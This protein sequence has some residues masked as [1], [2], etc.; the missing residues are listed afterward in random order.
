MDGVEADDVV[1]LLGGDVAALD[2]GAEV[3]VPPLTAGAPVPLQL[4][5]V[6]RRAPLVRPVP[7]HEAPET[8]VLLRR[9][10]HS[11]PLPEHQDDKIDPLLPAVEERRRSM[12]LDTDRGAA[13]ATS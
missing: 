11:L 9:P 4:G 3:E 12:G 13:V 10:C 1:L 5:A 2:A 7:R 6:G 8:L